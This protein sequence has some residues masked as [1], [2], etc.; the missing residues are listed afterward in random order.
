MPRKK[1]KKRDQK[2]NL[3]KVGLDFERVILILIKRVIENEKCPH[4][5][6]NVS[7]SSKK[8]P[9]LKNVEIKKFAS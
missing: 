4:I 5:L 8:F 9:D 6:K 7:A 1:I 3:I 2:V